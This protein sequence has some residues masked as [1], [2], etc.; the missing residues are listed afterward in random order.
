MHYVWWV[1][2]KLTKK[3]KEKELEIK[4]KEKYYS[5]EFLYWSSLRNNKVKGDFYVV[6]HREKSKDHLSDVKNSNISALDT[7]ATVLM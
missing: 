4:S 5:A 2:I 6:A 3:E 1:F 7:G